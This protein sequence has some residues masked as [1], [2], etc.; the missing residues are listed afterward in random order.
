MNIQ[1]FAALAAACWFGPALKEG[2][3]GLVVSH[4]MWA[5]GEP[6]YRISY[7][8]PANEGECNAVSGYGATPFLAIAQAVQE[9]ERRAQQA[10]ERTTEALRM[11]TAPEP[12]E[13]DAAA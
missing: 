1:D 13:A 12:V 9:W 3:G 11:T 5:T 10:A 7:Y 6:E 2:R 4:Q 8:M